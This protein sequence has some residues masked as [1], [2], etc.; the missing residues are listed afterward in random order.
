MNSFNTLKENTQ[1]IFKQFFSDHA[2]TTIQAPGRVNIIGEHTDYNDGFVLPCAINYQTVITGAP[3]QDNIINVI[4]ADYDQQQDS[5]CLEDEIVQHPTYMWANYVRG[6]IK[7]LKILTED[8]K[9][10]FGGANLVISGNVPQG[11]GLSSSA[12][13]EVAVGKIF[14]VLYQLPLTAQ[15]LAQNGQ[16]AEN[17]FVGC[18]CGIMD[19][20]ISAL[21][22]A[23]HALLLDCRNL[24]TRLVPIPDDTAIVI[25]NSNVKRGLVGSEYN[26]RRLQ[27]E[28]AAQALAIP[29][30]RDA[31]LEQLNNHKQQLDAVIYKRA[32][33]IITENMRTLKAADALTQSDLK[34]MGMLMAESHASMRDDFEITAP[35][36]D[37]L[38]EIVKNVIGD[39][40]GVRMTGGGFGGCIV[41]L[42]PQELVELVRQQV[43]KEY[44][45]KTGLHESFYICHAA[46][47]ASLT[48]IEL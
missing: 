27:C 22:R 29:A 37:I 9:I 43:A 15:E 7:Y 45:V 16:L 25:I 26:S 17:A 48:S 2:T 13:L 42:M 46:M 31:T 34:T 19:Q 5:F 3:R 23:N 4:A 33:H 41:A 32:H 14:Q 44:F 20:M 6:V 11:A 40:G 24:E 28:A 35:P 21:G 38:V 36:V 1:N 10:S 39:R 47:G 30:L 12:S 8:K 18:Q